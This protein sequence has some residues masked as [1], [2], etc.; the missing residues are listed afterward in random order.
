MNFRDS[1]NLKTV[2]NPS[3][4]LSIT[5]VTYNP[6]A[7][8]LDCLRSLT[9]G[10]AGLRY[11]VILVDNNSQDGMVDAA[12]QQYPDIE[13]ILNKDNRGFAAANNQGLARARG[14]YLLLLNPD[15]IV[16][17]AALA[18]MVTYLEQHTEVGIVGARTFDAAGDVAL[19]AYGRYTPLSILWQYWG[20]DR[21][22]PH[23]VFGVYRRACR[24]ATEPF[25]VNW[26][27]GHCLMMRRTV[28]EKIGGLDEG[29]FLFAEEPDFCERAAKAGWKTVYLPEATVTHQESSAVARYPLVKM[30]H[31]HI[32]P[33]HYF[34]KRGQRA[35][36]WAL[37]LGFA[38]E[39]GF[40]WLLRAAQ[41]RIRPSETTRARLVAY[42]VVIREMWRY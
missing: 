3:L 21:L 31:Y 28:Y 42:P 15:V 11:D 19:S 10:A 7:I 1:L 32:S 22:F 4:M 6:G 20:G 12:I 17:R 35:A 34:R 2:Q 27:Q 33:L 26:V 16:G 37:K 18:Q 23:Q 39:L 36:V 9:G 30:R 13:I 38:L 5:I 40:K 8:L 29:L 24:E 25:A 14:G 41:N